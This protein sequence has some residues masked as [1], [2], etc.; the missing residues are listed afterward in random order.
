LP[1]DLGLY[2]QCRAGATSW[3]WP[4]ARQVVKVTTRP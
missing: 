1:L 4:V 2:E 3:G